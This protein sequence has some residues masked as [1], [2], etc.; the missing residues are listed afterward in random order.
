VK[1]CHVLQTVLLQ[2]YRISLHSFNV[3]HPIFFASY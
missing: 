3:L 1:A 2:Y